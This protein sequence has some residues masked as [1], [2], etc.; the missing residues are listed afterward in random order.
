MP[1]SSATPSD[2]PQFQLAT[3]VIMIMLLT[4]GLLVPLAM[5]QGVISERQRLQHQVEAAIAESAAGEQQ[6]SGPVLVVPYQLRAD[7]QEVETR[8]RAAAPEPT[9]MKVIVP[10]TLHHDGDTVVDPRQKGIYRALVFRHRAKMK[11]QFVLPPQFG[12]EAESDG[13]R[14]TLVLGEPFVVIAASDMRGFVRVPAL[15]WNG[16]ET[17]VQAGTRLPFWPSGVHALVPAIASPLLDASAAASTHELEVDMEL[18]GT[19]SLSFAPLA[20]TTSIQLRADWPHPSFGGRWLPVEKSIRA[21]GF[22]ARWDVSRLAN[23]NAA[24]FSTGAPL[25]AKLPGLDRIEIG[26]V[27]PLSIYL[28][29]E[30]AVKYGVLFIALTFIAFFVFESLHGLHHGLRIHPLQYGFVGLA[31][32]VFFLLLV[33]LSEHLSFGLAYAIATLACVAVIGYYVA[34]VLRST[35]RAVAF[36]GGMLALFGVLYAVL[37]SEDLALLM[38]SL[39]VFVCLAVVMVLTRR[40]DWY[41][42]GSTR[43]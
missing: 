19:R 34:A 39:V 31:L 43:A 6:L 16:T 17:R 23:N 42:L 38:G 33:S 41:A 40:V 25:P 15:R 37:Q 13:R 24:L 12:I 4:L 7:P 8:R 21:D 22:S 30:R 14:R 28:Q 2:K 32:C 29:S 9:L 35:R 18:M 10:T 26:L 27:E 36:A 1:P 5:V 20:E 11:A 3:K